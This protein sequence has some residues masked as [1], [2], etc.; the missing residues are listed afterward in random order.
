[1]LKQGFYWNTPLYRQKSIE[2]LVMTVEFWPAAMLRAR[3]ASVFAALVVVCAGGGW[4]GTSVTFELRNDTV[5]WNETFRSRE[6]AFI[7]IDMWNYHWCKTATARAAALIPRLNLATAAM[8]SAGVHVI[9]SPTDVHWWYTGVPQRERAVSFRRW[10]VPEKL[11]IPDPPAPHLHGTECMC[12]EPHACYANYAESSMNPQVTV[13]DSDF[14]VAGIKDSDPHAVATPG[15]AP[16]SREVSEMYSILKAHG[17]TTVIYAGIHENVCVVGKS[18]AVMEMQR[19]GF[20]TL[21]ARDLTDAIT[22]YDG[23]A[24]LNPDQGTRNTT[25]WLE[26]SVLSTLEIS[27]WLRSIGKWPEAAVDPVLIT[28]W[29]VQSRP[30][31]YDGAVTVRLSTACDVQWDCTSF[32]EVIIKY[33]VNSSS[34]QCQS[35]LTCVSPCTVTINAPGTSILQASAVSSITGEL[36][37]T[38]S[39]AVFIQRVSSQAELPT[40]HVDITRVPLLWRLGAGFR[41][42]PRV[43][44]SYVFTALVIRGERYE[45]G[46]GLKAPIAIEWDVSRYGFARFVG[47]IGMDDGYCATGDW[48]REP[49]NCHGLAQWSGFEVLLIL[50][51]VILSRS[52]VMRLMSTPW[53]FSVPLRPRSRIMRLAVARPLSGGTGSGA[54]DNGGTYTAYVNLVQAGFL[55]Q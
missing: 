13:G 16:G 22:G 23:S 15:D 43:N 45:S 47:V 30:H 49:W 7:V 28:P 39:E 21:L 48:D 27:T 38:E 20:R 6:L 25:A 4:P 51:G 33:S 8:R 9:H 52:P 53:V 17:V 31:I 11:D 34:H 54:P 37:F 42:N 19:L 35:G 40:P 44:S 5:S 24:T 29:G 3:W 12:G 32:G 18:T 26:K 55:Y 1:M 50:D 2:D 10:P 36:L 46:L 14:I 41:A